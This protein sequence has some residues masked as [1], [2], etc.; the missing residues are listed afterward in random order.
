[1]NKKDYIDAMN[2]I[3]VSEKV[4]KS[5]LNKIKEQP[6]RKTYN[7]LFPL[8]SLAMACMVLMAFLLPHNSLAP[9]L[10]N[11][12]NEQETKQVGELPNI[13][14]FENMY[15]ILK[16]R[17]PE[18]GGYY[19]YRNRGAIFSDDEIMMNAEQSVDSATKSTNSVKETADQDYSK[20]NIQVEGVDEADIVKTD[21]RYIY[22]LKYN[23]LNIIDTENGDKLVSAANLSF[24]NGSFYPDE[25][26]V[27][28]DK[29]V[30]IGTRELESILSNF[31]GRYSYSEYTVAKIYDIKDRS[32]PKEDR[33]VEIEGYYLS[34]RMINNNLYLISN[35][36]NYNA[37][38]CE[39]REID[40]LNENDFKPKYK[41][42]AVSE[43][44]K[45]VDFNCIWYMPESDDTSYLNIAAFDVTKDKEANISSYLGAG[46]TIYS[47]E[48]N[49]F[50]VRTRY[51]YDYKKTSEPTTEV[52]KFELKG[53]KC[54]FLK[55]GSVPGTVLNQFS[56]D[57]KDG[58]FRIATT[59]DNWRD[60]STNNLYVL[61]KNL[62]IVGKVEDLAEGERIYS[63]RFM[64]DRAYMVTFV[65]TDPLFVIDLKDPKNPQVLGELKIP[66]YSKY[67][68][69]YDDTHIIGF[70]EDTNVV[71]Y[72][73]GDRVITDG[74]K[75]ALFDVT[76]PEN[77]KEMYSV[78]IG[79]K[80]TYSELLY[81]HKALL[82]SKE[83]NIIAFPISITEEDYRVTF[84]GAIVYGLNLEKG[85]ELKGKIS[86]L[87]DDTDK[88]YG[89]N[90][91]ERIIYI[92]DTIYTLSND[93]V[94]A[95]DMNSMKTKGS[96]KLK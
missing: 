34:S 42:T 80:G 21:G 83:K 59:K 12:N 7:K 19:G 45:H 20:T 18:Y 44:R 50:I 35:E 68:H 47:S 76:D 93:L 77:P 54:E 70:G 56:M 49:L 11:A 90:N 84:Q 66:G 40:E 6:K 71:N 1:M 10:P 91:V 38:L 3:E 25:I 26:F 14:N 55:K 23:T 43:T 87:N 13:K 48:D 85:F 58:Y 17:A 78:K 24:N 31:T 41:D 95:T 28:D 32:N 30:I 52:Y 2:E 36:Y 94:K 65:E 88:Y 29:L 53:D 82:F 75:M 33:T 67:L 51:D 60:E 15:A 73:Y 62:E 22:Y 8:A 64:G 96:L 4:K 69:P 86:N 27:K 5:T 37:Y 79:E 74:M 9:G 16:E 81:N 92:K 39:E 72:G 46:S 89:R 63:V 57:E 61:D